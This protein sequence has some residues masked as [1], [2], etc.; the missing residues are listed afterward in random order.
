VS[1]TFKSYVQL[2]MNLRNDGPIQSLTHSDEC[3]LKN[4]ISMQSL[5][6]VMYKYGGGCMWIVN[7]STT[8]QNTAILDWFWVLKFRTKWTQPGVLSHVQLHW[9]GG[10]RVKAKEN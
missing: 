9:G 7:F 3:K 1:F 8:L 6:F 5:Q 2:G 10:G 4:T